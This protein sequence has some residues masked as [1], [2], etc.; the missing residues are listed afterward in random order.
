VL[1]ATASRGIS[2]FTLNY[3][4]LAYHKKSQYLVYR[5]FETADDA[6]VGRPSES[7]WQIEVDDACGKNEGVVN[8]QTTEECS[9]PAA[10][11]DMRPDEQRRV[12]RHVVS[13]YVDDDRHGHTRFESRTAEFLQSQKSTQD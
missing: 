6:D 2:S 11:E 13:P 4:T 5:A 12:E 8:T 3:T 10:G 1:N 9:R 7:Q